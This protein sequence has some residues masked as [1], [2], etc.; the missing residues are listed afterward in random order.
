[1]KEK[2]PALARFVIEVLPN[3]FYHINMV[4]GSDE[5]VMG[6]QETISQRSDLNL[7]FYFNHTSFVDP[8]LAGDIIRRI[9]PEGQI[10]A[11]I[12]YSHTEKKLK[13]IPIILM[14]KIFETYGV[15]TFSVVQTYQRKDQEKYH[16]SSE[17]ASRQNMAFLR[18]IKKLADKGTLL[19]IISPEGHRSETGF[20]QKAENGII[21]AGTMLAPVLY[22]PIGIDFERGCFRKRVN[23]S[24]GETYLQETGTDKPSIDLLMH[25]L[26]MALPEARR[27]FYADAA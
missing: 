7:I 1:M 2:S 14:N 12:S 24:I 5:K 17:I 6:I 23:L 16:Y 18:G 8:L 20:L 19:M 22:V 21:T 11:P 9:N 15:K 3:V 13:N 26:A 4:D 25:N 27:G 10:V